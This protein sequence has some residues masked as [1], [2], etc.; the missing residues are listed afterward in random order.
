MTEINTGKYTPAMTAEIKRAAVSAA[1]TASADALRKN[2]DRTN[3][4]NVEKV[5]QVT[6]TYMQSCS[7]IGLL[8][9]MEGLAA[10]LGCS[11]VW[12]YKFIATNPDSPTSRYLDRLRLSWASIRMALC[13]RGVLEPG[14]ALFVLKN[15]HLGMSDHPEDIQPDQGEE[16]RRPSWADRLSDEEYLERLLKGIEEPDDDPEAKRVAL[17]YLSGSVK[18]PDQHEEGDGAE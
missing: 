16:E 1:V 13:E 10:C 6:E 18:S 11:R 7:N 8:P 9:S 2:P 4:R 15:S 12:L 3:L 14:G 5:K 17:K